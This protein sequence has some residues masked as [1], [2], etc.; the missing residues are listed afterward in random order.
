[1]TRK[2]AQLAVA[3]FLSLSA[4]SVFSATVTSSFSIDSATIVDLYSATF[5]GPITP[6]EGFFGGTPPAGRAITVVENSSASGNFSVSWDDQTGEIQTVNNMRI[7]LGDMTITIAGTT[8]TII[9]VINGNAAPVADDQA[10][11]H[12][13]TGAAPSHTA[14]ADEAP[15]NV[16]IF[17]HDDA[18]NEDAPDFATFTDIVDTCTGDL[19]ALIGILSLDSVRYQLDGTVN[20]NG[21]DSIQLMAQSANNSIYTVDLTTAVVPVP[22]AVWLFGSALG[23]LGWIR[24]RVTA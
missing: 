8:P 11:I 9:E 17:Q 19:C 7:N 14:D 1:M 13:G 18:P 21:G 2:F 22:A 6:G 4:S 10:Y 15:G 16:S 3:M 20:A 12:A 24:S 23:L 5:D